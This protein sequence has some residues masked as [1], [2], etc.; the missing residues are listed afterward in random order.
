[1]RGLLSSAILLAI[2]VV[3]LVRF[4]KPWLMSR[5]YGVLATI[6]LIVSMLRRT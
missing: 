2:E 1:M 4:I 3:L 5:L 6:L